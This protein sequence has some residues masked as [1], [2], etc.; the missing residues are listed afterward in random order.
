[1][2][3]APSMQQVGRFSYDYVPPPTR[4]NEVGQNSGANMADPIA[5]PDLDDP[6]EQEKMRKGAV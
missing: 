3:Q 4:V 5:V 1:M 6:K 2:T